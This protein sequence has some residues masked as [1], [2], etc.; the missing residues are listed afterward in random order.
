MEEPGAVS[1][2]FQLRLNVGDSTEEYQ[3]A[4]L[5]IDCGVC[6]YISATVEVAVII[7]VYHSNRALIAVGEGVFGGAAALLTVANRLN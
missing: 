3:I 5:P 7:V 2:H 4:S 1:I 6:L